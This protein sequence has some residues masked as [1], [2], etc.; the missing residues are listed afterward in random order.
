LFELI[1]GKKPDLS[2]LREWRSNIWVYQSSNDKLGGC[3]RKGWWI[4]YDNKSNGFHIYFSDTS[5]IKVERNF[6]FI[7][8]DYS[9][10]LMGCDGS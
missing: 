3:G 2:G 4:G 1:Y 10:L 8:E 5:A 7:S 9:V 6:C